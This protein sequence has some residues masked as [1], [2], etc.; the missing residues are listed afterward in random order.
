MVVRCFGDAVHQLTDRNI[1]HII[2]KPQYHRNALPNGEVLQVHE[3]VGNE[4]PP[5][6]LVEDLD[7]WHL[8]VKQLFA[9][10]FIT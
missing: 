3:R 5:I 10:V 8:R 6:L 1:A 4:V 2:S 9:K 7:A